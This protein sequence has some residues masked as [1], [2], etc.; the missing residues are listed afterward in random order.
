MNHAPSASPSSDAA[1]R[2][3]PDEKALS[4]DDRMRQAVTRIE[5]SRSA[6]IVCLSPEPPPVRRGSTPGAAGD[7]HAPPSFAETLA[8][9]IERNGLLQ[10]SWRTARTLA[11]RWWTRQP[12]HSSVDLVGQTLLHQARP[13]MRRHPMTTLAVGATLG[14]GLVFLVSTVRPWA[15]RHIQ[16]QANPWR[17]RMGSLVWT[18]LTSTPVQMA[19]AGAL[20]SWLSNQGN[21]DTRSGD[22]STSATPRSAPA[23]A[24]S[25]T[26]AAA[27]SL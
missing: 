15:W 25:S 18:Q 5:A 10:G 13:V 8:A 27:A 26:E 22:A 1:R 4:A 21:R 23:G 7:G 14:A 6:L 16:G 9:R 19:L 20:A 11:R 2:F 3:Q 12:W 17:D 24:A